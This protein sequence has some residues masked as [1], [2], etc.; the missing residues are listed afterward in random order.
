MSPLL[1]WLWRFVIWACSF[2]RLPHR[3]K[4]TPLSVNYHFTRQCNYQCG[5]CFHTALTSY[6]MP[7]DDA[8]RGLALLARAGMRKL[9]FAGGEPFLYPDFLGQLCR[10]AKTE[11]QLESVSIVSNGSKITRKWLA[12]FGPHVDILA[13]SCDSFSE[14]TN[15]AIGRG[16]GSHLAST[17]AVAAWCRELGVGFKLNTVVNRYN[18]RED[19]NAEIAALRPMRWKVFQVLTIEGENDGGSN[20]RRD[21]RSFNVSDEEFRQFVARHS[22]RG[23]PMVVEDNAKMRAS[24]LIL[25]ERMRF[26]DCSGGR[27]QPSGSIL[28][29]GVARALAASG[30]DQDMFLK[31]GG[32][33]EWTRKDRDCS[34]RPPRDIEDLCR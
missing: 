24:Y 22:G 1:A 30:F 23:L 21:A 3:R 4:P 33:Y 9:N 20:S 5:F 13:V 31:R 27:K 19:M 16:A 11:L 10:Y 28:D 14:E 25:D 29:V 18:W 26:L 2:L 12:E 32:R 34:E 7:L 17:R 15:K 8:K 6:M